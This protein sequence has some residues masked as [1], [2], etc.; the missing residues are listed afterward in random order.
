MGALIYSLSYLYRQSCKHCTYT[1][2]FRCIL[3]A[4]R[5]LIM[6]RESPPEDISE[7]LP[8]RR[9]ASRDL[10]FDS[11]ILFAVQF[12]HEH[13]KCR[14]RMSSSDPYG[15]RMRLYGRGSCVRARG[16]ADPSAAA[17]IVG[18]AIGDP[19]TYRCRVPAR[20]SVHTNLATFHSM[21]WRDYMNDKRAHVGETMSDAACTGSSAGRRAEAACRLGLDQLRLPDLSREVLL[22]LRECRRCA[23]ELCLACSLEE[24]SLRD[25]G[26]SK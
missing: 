1:Q 18:D 7:A 17:L 3:V 26:S 19:I 14:A 22:A 13:A 5:K 23:G 2:S 11:T 20:S 12:T 4:G 8:R 9:G 24:R 25:P 10:A 15:T 21:K 6:T 16:C